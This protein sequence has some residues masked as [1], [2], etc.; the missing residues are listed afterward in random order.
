MQVRAK[1]AWAVWLLAGPSAVVWSQSA[2]T[3]LHL[4][5]SG[6][7]KHGDIQVTCF[8]ILSP[9]D[10]HQPLIRR[11][12]VETTKYD[13]M[14]GPE[15]AEIDPKDGKTITDFY[16]V[17]VWV[18]KHQEQNTPIGEI[19]LRCSSQG[20]FDDR[21][22]QV[23]LSLTEDPAT[24]ALTPN[25]SKFPL[26]SW[27]RDRQMVAIDPADSDDSTDT[28][29]KSSKQGNTFSEG[30]A[31]SG[32]GLA[33]NVSSKLAQSMPIDMH[34]IL[35]NRAGDCWEK[36]GSQTDFVPGQTQEIRSLTVTSPK[37]NPTRV[38]IPVDFKT[39]CALGSNV[40]DVAGND[41]NAEAD[42]NIVYTPAGGL[43]RSQL[44]KFKVSLKPPALALLLGAITGLV[45][46]CAVHIIALR[47]KDRTS[48]R[49]LKEVAIA[50]GTVVAAEAFCFIAMTL[51]KPNTF[52]GVN[53]DPRQLDPCFAIALLASGGTTI[54]R[55]LDRTKKGLGDDDEQHH[56]ENAHP[57]GED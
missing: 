47:K 22:G 8:G 12:L 30:L 4:S 53:L 31:T 9:L 43:E 18:F 21:F 56:E 41:T 14:L 25:F 7:Y 11:E 48:Q 1:L 13:L 28:S 27:D 3:L 38:E 19:V 37:Q 44:V 24:E 10:T 2:S 33:M 23:G 29:D 57:E 40:V 51:H 6:T 45:I 16:D 39:W 5:L 36:L 26:H 52:W 32:E 54:R 34:L 35:I 46:G 20:A 42:L 15:S 50:I 17:P 49:I 55:F